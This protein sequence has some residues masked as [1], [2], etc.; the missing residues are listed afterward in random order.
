MSENTQSAEGAEHVRR[1][2]TLQGVVVSDKMN[3]T[4]VVK[5][6]RQVMH[7]RYKKIVR[8]SKR[9]KAHDEVEQAGIGDLVTIVESRPLSKSKRWRL[10]SIDR[11]A[12][13]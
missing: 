13:G 4:V 1:R 8:Q 2:R 3:K 10:Q 12:G 5:V 6:T 9:Y 7:P 11:K